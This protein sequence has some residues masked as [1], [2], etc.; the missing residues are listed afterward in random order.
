LKEWIRTL[1]IGG[2]LQL[3]LPNMKWA[4]RLIIEGGTQEE[5]DRAM[6]FYYSAQKGDLRSAYKDVHLAGFTPQS[7]KELLSQLSTLEGVSVYTT[8]GNFGNWDAPE[9]I[10]KDDMG[11][12]IVAIATKKKHDAPVSLKLPIAMQEEAKYHIGEKALPVKTKDGLSKTKEK[13]NVKRKI[14][15]TKAGKKETQKKIIVKKAK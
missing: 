8:E 12:N 7:I 14:L 3:V 11:Y 5:M 15:K 10:R 4:S 13:V 1:K 9:N 2:K 6:W